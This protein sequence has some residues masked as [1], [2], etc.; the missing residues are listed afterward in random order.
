MAG[1]FVIRALALVPIDVFVVVTSQILSSWAASFFWAFAV[2]CWPSGLLAIFYAGALF[3]IPSFFA[4]LAHF[5][6]APQTRA[7]VAVGGILHLV[8]SAI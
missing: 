5:I 8:G 6:A 3:K 7:R 2:H 4:G 1:R